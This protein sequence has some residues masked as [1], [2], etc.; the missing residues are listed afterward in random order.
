[1]KNTKIIVNTRSKSY[2]IYI[3]DKIL[4]TTGMLIRKKLPNVKKISIISDKKLPLS[5]LRKL[6]KSLKRYNPKI[7]RLSVSE[8]IKNFKVAYQL[9]ENMLNNNFNRSDCIISFGGGILGDLSAFV[10]S[11]TKRG[12]KFINIPTTH[13]A[14]SDASVGGKTAVNS[15]QGKNLIG[16]FYQP[17]FVLIDMSMLN[18]LPRRE[19]FENFSISTNHFSTWYTIEH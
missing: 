14:Q 2:P 6:S 17:E 9:I 11:L 3:G 18:S 5:A 8:K 15:N 7:Y 4:N 19:M 10:S 13:L 1:M 12:V 16:T